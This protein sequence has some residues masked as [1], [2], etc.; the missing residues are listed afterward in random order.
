MIPF[1]PGLFFVGR[2][3][4]IINSFNKYTAIRVICFFL[5]EVCKLNVQGICPFCP[6]WICTGINVSIIYHYCHFTEVG[7]VMIYPIPH[8]TMVISAFAIYQISLTRSFS[9]LLNSKTSFWFHFPK[10]FSVSYFINFWSDYFLTSV[11]FVSFALNFLIS[12]D[13]RV[14]HWFEITFF[15]LIQRF[16]AIN[17]SNH[18]LSCISQVVILH[19]LIFSQLKIF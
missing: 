4:T 5:T 16:H 14:G 9:I 17:L 3:L 15:P 13:R 11:N 2:F 19:V 12:K 8:L 6:S 10:F 7:L 1:E 18:C